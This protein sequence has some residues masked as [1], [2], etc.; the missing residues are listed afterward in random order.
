MSVIAEASDVEDDNPT[1]MTN[2]APKVGKN[3]AI[4]KKVG[5]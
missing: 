1:K 5:S 4:V 3:G 2:K